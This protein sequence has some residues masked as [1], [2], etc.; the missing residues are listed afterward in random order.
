MIWP[1]RY[2]L[3]VWMPTSSDGAATKLSIAVLPSRLASR[4]VDDDFP[5]PRW[6]KQFR[7]PESSNL[8]GSSDQ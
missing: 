4:S 1:D 3:T 2:A 8:D 7:A 5:N 6:K